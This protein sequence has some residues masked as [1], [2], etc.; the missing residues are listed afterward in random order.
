MRACWAASS[1]NACA[2]RWA[3]DARCAV[4]VTADVEKVLFGCVEM[5]PR[6]CSWQARRWAAAV[7]RA[8]ALA[9]AEACALA[10]AFACALA[11][12]L[13][14]ARAVA[15]ACALAVARAFRLA[16]LRCF[17][18]VLATGRRLGACLTRWAALRAFFAFRA[19]VRV[20]ARARL[21]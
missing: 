6:L 16:A 13:A 12:A 9:V 15:L 2:T 7:R 3:R 21:A 5:V 11:V 14:C 19:V 4:S 1:R 17:F 20:T 18:T 10:V 8:V